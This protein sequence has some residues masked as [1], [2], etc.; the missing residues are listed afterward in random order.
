MKKEKTR[1][2]EDLMAA[3]AFAEAG[4]HEYALWLAGTSKREKLKRKR[5]SNRRFRRSEER[6]QMRV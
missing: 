5:A 1:W 4:Q 2:F 6:P 3:V